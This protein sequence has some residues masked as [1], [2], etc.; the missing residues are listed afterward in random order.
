MLSKCASVLRQ[1]VTHTC[2]S[3]IRKTNLKTYKLKFTFVIFFF[4]RVSECREY[5]FV[6]TSILLRYCEYCEYFY[7]SVMNL[8]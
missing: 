3:S 6:Q 2:I 1:C 7:K 5:F 4:T 8:L